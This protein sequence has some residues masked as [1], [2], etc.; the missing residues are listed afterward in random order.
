LRMRGIDRVDNGLDADGRVY[1][2]CWDVVRMY[3]RVCYSITDV[4]SSAIHET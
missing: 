3:F 2:D 4:A 1:L